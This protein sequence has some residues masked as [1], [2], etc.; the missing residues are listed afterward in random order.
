MKEEILDFL[1]ECICNHSVDE[2]STKRIWEVFSLLD[3]DVDDLK[4]QFNQGRNDV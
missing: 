1:K 3:Y 2:I 4:E